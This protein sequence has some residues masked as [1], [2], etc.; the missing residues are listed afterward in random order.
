LEDLSYLAVT[1]LGGSGVPTM[2]P[3]P[4][5]DEEPRLG[6]RG[7]MIVSELSLTMG[8]H[9]SAA[10]GHTVWSDLDLTVKEVTDQPALKAC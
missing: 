9:G 3:A 4:V 1:D 8:V 10:L 2:R 5:G 6:G 7:L